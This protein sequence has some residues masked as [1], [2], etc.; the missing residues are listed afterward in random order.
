ML[1]KYSV[2]LVALLLLAISVVAGLSQQKYYQVVCDS[3]SHGSDPTVYSC[4]TSYSAAKGAADAH[5]KNNP[6]HSATVMNESGCS[7]R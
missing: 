5:M 2:L 1:R 4:M 3:R 6:G 7:E